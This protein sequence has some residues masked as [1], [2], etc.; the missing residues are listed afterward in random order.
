MGGWL[1]I[2]YTSRAL[3]AFNTYDQIQVQQAWLYA[4]KATDGS[5]GLRDL[6]LVGADGL[7]RDATKLDRARQEVVTLLDGAAAAR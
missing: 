1:Q 5:C 6:R 2:G 3:P 7:M 4:E